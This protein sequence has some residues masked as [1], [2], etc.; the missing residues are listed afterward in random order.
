MAFVGAPVS[1]W[2]AFVRGGQSVCRSR[3]HTSGNNTVRMGYGDY[4]I[5]TDKT[6]GHTNN[7]YIDKF[8]IASDFAK[9][10]AKTDADAFLGRDAKGA[11]LV[12]EEGIPQITEGALARDTAS[13]EDPRVAESK[14]AVW[15]WDA[16]YSEPEVFADTS[17]ATV[18]EDAFLAFRD[19]SA[20]ERGAALTAQD[21]GAALRNKMRL[22]N[23]F[24]EN[25]LLTLEGQHDRLHALVERITEV[26]FLTP[27]G[28][29]QTEIPGMPYMG[30][31]GALDFQK[32]PETS[33]A[34][35]KDAPGAAPVEAIPAVYKRPKGAEK[36]DLPYN[37]APAISEIK[38]DQA[39]AGLIAPSE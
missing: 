18:S 36:M 7:Y 35:W 39:A 25:F 19:A 17:D 3:T 32:K 28:N 9:A 31:V 37:T 11:V 27:I 1:D 33:V 14:G 4:S 2:R 6:Q 15:E 20:A 10:P 34:S 38:K 13:P 24:S 23:G 8:R 26:P 12:P 16:G 30:S 22:E 21:L 5:L 29:Y